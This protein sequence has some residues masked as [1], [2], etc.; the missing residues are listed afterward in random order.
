MTRE[1]CLIE[2]KTENSNS[3][4]KPWRTVTF[5]SKRP[6]HSA[7]KNGFTQTIGSALINSYYCF[8]L[9]FKNPWEFYFVLFFFSNQ[10]FTI[11]NRLL[12][13]AF[14]RTWVHTFNDMHD[15]SFSIVF[16]PQHIRGP[17]NNRTGIYSDL[18]C[19]NWSNRNYQGKVQITLKV[20]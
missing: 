17:C 15:A 14:E 10:F 16:F 19:L 9:E 20:L 2:F 3:H 8:H 13:E 12:G 11:D 7:I 18:I 1:Q 4:F 5:D 6:Y